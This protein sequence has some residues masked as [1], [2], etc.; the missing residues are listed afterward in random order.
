[1]TSSYHTLPSVVIDLW[2]TR[3]HD[4]RTDPGHMADD[5]EAEFVRTEHSG[6]G[7]ACRQLAAAQKLRR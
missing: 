1:M 3:H 6:H 4:C 7:A 5:R 2:R